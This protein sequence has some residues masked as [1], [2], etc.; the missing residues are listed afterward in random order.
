MSILRDWFGNKPDPLL[1]RA[2]NLVQAA[3]DYAVGMF[4]PLLERFPILRQVDTGH[5]D[6]V[7]TV[8]GV[9]MAATRLNNMRLES[10]REEQLMEVVAARLNE[11]KPDGIRGFEDCKGLFENEFDRLNAVGHDPQFVAS[12]AVGKWI[13]WNIL[14]RP[15]ET[16]EECMLVRST[17][18]LATHTFFGWW[19]K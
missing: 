17:G 10:A 18:T 6:F 9:F 11:W 2:E 19:D 13:V 5:W 3:Q 12:D 14:G 1:G 15:P 4:P 16:D 7:L 8:A